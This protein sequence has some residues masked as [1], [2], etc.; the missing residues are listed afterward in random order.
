MRHPG[1]GAEYTVG[2]AHPGF[3][4]V[5]QVGVGNTGVLRRDGASSRRLSEIT[6]LPNDFQLLGLFSL[7][8]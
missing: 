4:G 8:S 3:R 5:A 6:S 1:G 7:P 2:C